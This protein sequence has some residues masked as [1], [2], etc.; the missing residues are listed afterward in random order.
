MPNSSH[1]LGRQEFDGEKQASERRSKG[2]C[3]A[4]VEIRMGESRVVRH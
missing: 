4:A 2:D 1:A 3:Q